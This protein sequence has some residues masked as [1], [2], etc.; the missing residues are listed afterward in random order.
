MV[1]LIFNHFLI[2]Y[3]PSKEIFAIKIKLKNPDQHGNKKIVFHFS[4]NQKELLFASEVI[5]IL[6]VRLFCIFTHFEYT[7]L[8]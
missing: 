7:V 8:I 4:N 3:R 5:E 1:L 6:Q 2:I